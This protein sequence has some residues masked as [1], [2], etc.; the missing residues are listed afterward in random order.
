[1]HILD[2]VQNSIAAGAATIN[3]WVTEDL[4]ADLMEITISDNGR[5]MTP[6]LVDR[7][8]DPFFTTRTTRKVGLGI[9]LFKAAAERCGGWLTIQSTVGEGTLVTARFQHSHID[10]APLGD[11]V[12]TIVV[13]LVCNPEVNLVYRHTLNGL[14]FSFA[15]AEVRRELDGVPINAPPVVSW[16]REYISGSLAQLRSE[17]GG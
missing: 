9:P 1:M 13:L 15:A 3:I 2:L 8:S 7:V 16:I 6:E 14:E 4:K 17:A 11:M 5:G 12:E 10:R